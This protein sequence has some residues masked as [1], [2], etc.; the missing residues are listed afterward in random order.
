[1]KEIMK[2]KN[3]LLVCC[4]SGALISASDAPGQMF[5]N[6]YSFTALQMTSP[7]TFT[8]A[9]GAN[10]YAGLV[11]SG[12]RLY[13]TAYGG[14]SFNT[15][16]AFAID[17]NGSD[18]TNLHNFFGSGGS[19]PYGRLVF[20]DN[21]LYGVASQGSTGSGPGKIFRMNSDGSSYTVMRT[22]LPLVN[23]TNRDGATP[24][25]GLV[26][27]GETLYGTTL[28]GGSNG[29]GTIFSIN[30]NG[31]AFTNLHNFPALL[32][33]TNSDGALTYAGLIVSGNRLYGTAAAGGNWGSGTVFAMETNGSNFTVLHHF[34]SSIDFTNSDGANPRGA[35]IESAGVLYGTTS[36]GGGSAAGTVFALNIDGTGFTNLH[37]FTGLSGNTNTDGTH[38]IGGL[39]ISGN[40]LYGTTTGGGSV[41][42]GTI[43]SIKNDGSD[44][45]SL[46]G[47][48]GVG[49]GVSP[50]SDLTLSA[51]VLYGTTVYG[52]DANNGTVF[53]LGLPASSAPQ[54]MIASFGADIVL[55]W[56]T[57]FPGFTLEANVHLNTNIWSIVTN[58]PTVSGTNNVVTDA[59]SDSERFYR[60]RKL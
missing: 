41:G 12:N 35:L 40:T 37:R 54:L 18:F 7:M 45:T 27:A 5:T 15:G 21:S 42:A 56:A 46:Y 52:G 11:L 31:N 34:A 48:T 49:D 1:M 58:A 10:P 30:T 47:F 24:Y 32:N 8:N 38:P 25:A 53:S 55:S 19:R 26:L 29:W 33:S 57:N 28:V 50:S 60:L 23:S 43:F 17:A 6:L 44:F 36:Y 16:T 51:N 13:G 3:L 22:F 9:D 39:L 59:V 2:T 14:G 20:S 4:L